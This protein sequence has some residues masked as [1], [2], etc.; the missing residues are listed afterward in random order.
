MRRSGA[1]GEAR[2]YFWRIVDWRDVKAAWDFSSAVWFWA[3][4]MSTI[5]PEVML[6][7]RRMEGNSICRAVSQN[8]KPCIW[9]RCNG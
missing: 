1:S 7:G 3:T 6:G 8:V 9:D 5:E 2:P 4:V